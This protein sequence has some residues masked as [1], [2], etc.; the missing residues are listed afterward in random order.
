M[1]ATKRANLERLA[2]DEKTEAEQKWHEAFAWLPVLSEDGY[3]VWLDRVYRCRRHRFDP[4]RYI[5][6][7]HNIMTAVDEN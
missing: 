6:D 2:R 3:W 5:A 4:W 7:V 1:T